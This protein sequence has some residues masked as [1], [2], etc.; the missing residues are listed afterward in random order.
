M[1]VHAL[2]QSLRKPDALAVPVEDEQAVVT[3]ARLTA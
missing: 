2:V 1:A 3:P